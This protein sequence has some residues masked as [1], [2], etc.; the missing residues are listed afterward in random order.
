MV[1]Y[2]QECRRSNGGE[3][4]CNAELKTNM[5]LQ[6]RH[7]YFEATKRV[8]NDLRVFTDSMQASGSLF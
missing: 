5:T 2:T 6:L 3:L 1:L 7:Y 8:K 4:R